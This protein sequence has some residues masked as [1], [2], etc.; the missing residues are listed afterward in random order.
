MRA[1]REHLDLHVPGKLL[2]DIPR[3][4]FGAAV[5]IGAIALNNDRDLH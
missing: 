2:G 1:G 4:L 5:D 3:M